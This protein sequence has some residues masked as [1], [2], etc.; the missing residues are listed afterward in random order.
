MLICFFGLYNSLLIF[1]PACREIL[2]SDDKVLF[3]TMKILL[4]RDKTPQDKFFHQILND[5]D[6]GAIHEFLSRHL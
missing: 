2:T 3:C 6:L 4:E 5:A 1:K